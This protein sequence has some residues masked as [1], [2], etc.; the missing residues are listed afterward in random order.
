MALKIR[1]GTLWRREIENKP[2][3]F[4]EALEPFA[5]AGQNLKIVMGYTSASDAAK[6]N[7]AVEIF[8]V[9]DEKAKECAKK[10]GLHEMAHATCLI[11]EGDD[12]PGVAYKI[13]KA[14]ADS[15]INL[16]FAMCQAIGS[17]FQACFGFGSEADAAKAETAIEKI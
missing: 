12:K 1:K 7:G 3:T 8:P 9:T 4:A 16:H 13:A 14:I 5:S 2:G 17:Q 6:K 11:I 10:G 15:G